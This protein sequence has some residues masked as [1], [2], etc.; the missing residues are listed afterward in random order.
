M[1]NTKFDML[2]GPHWKRILWECSVCSLWICPLGFSI[3]TRHQVATNKLYA[4][5]SHSFFFERIQPSYSILEEH[6]VKLPQNIP[7]SWCSEITC[8]TKCPHQQSES[9][10]QLIVLGGMC[11]RPATQTSCCEDQENCQGRHWSETWADMAGCSIFSLDKK[12]IYA[13]VIGI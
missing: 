10:K 2:S 1:V 7:Y 11:D 8:I 9:A 5:P 12:Y 13:P 4:Q 3:S 6:A